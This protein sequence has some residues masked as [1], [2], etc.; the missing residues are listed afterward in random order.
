VLDDHARRLVE[1]GHQAPG[2]VEVEDVVERELLAL[3]LAR[4][5][6]RVE[7]RAEIAVEGRALVRVLAVAQVLHLLEAQVEAVRERLVGLGRHEAPV[8]HLDLREVGRDRGLVAA[9][10]PERLLREVEPRRR[11]DPA[12]AVEL[13]QQQRV[14]GGVDHH[15]HRREVLGRRAHHRGAADV[16]VLDR[17]GEARALRDLVLEGVEVHDHHVDRRDAVLLERL[18]VLGQVSRAR[19]SRRGSSGAAS[20]RARRGSPAIPWPSRPRSP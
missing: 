20:S 4:R 7:R 8:A 2:R 5:R 19:G 17:L 13:L 18:Q 16:D 1:L 3:Q 11:V 10:V 14:V 15:R 12:L 9:G 6:H